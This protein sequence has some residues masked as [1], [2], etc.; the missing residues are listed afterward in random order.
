MKENHFLKI[1]SKLK[2]FFYDFLEIDHKFAT[3][4]LKLAKLAG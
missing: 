2:S 3:G 4:V 1:S